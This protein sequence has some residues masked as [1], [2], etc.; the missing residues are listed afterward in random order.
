MNGL[1]GIVMRLDGALY[2]VASIEVRD[3]RIQG[4]YIQVN[5]EKL[6]NE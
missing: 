5:P 3:G 4:V 2:G 1:P 6:R